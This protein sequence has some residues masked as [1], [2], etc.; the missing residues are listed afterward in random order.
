MLVLPDCQV[1]EESIDIMRWA[2]VQSDPECWLGH[3]ASD[4]IMANDG[5]FKQALDRYKY[6][7]RYGLADGIV[8]RLRHGA[9][10]SE[11]YSMAFTPTTAKDLGVYAPIPINVDVLDRDQDGRVTSHPIGIESRTPWTSGQRY[12]EG[13]RFQLFFKQVIR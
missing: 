5:P 13:D 2:L 7:H 1:V 8:H 6:P 10:L 3:E 12:K 4:L 11:G 9:N